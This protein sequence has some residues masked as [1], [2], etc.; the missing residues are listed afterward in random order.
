MLKEL[1]EKLDNL[2]E[3][4]AKDIDIVALKALCTVPET[5]EIVAHVKELV[6]KLEA[7]YVND[8]EIKNLIPKDEMTLEKLVGLLE[9]KYST[10][11]D[12]ITLKAMMNLE[13]SIEKERAV[14]TYLKKINTED[15]DIKK[16]FE[17]KRKANKNLDMVF[18]KGGEYRPSFINE[19]IEKRVFN[20]NVCRYLTTQD[21]YEKIM[22]KN[23]SNFKN[24]K[25]PVENVS[26]WDA[27][28]YCNRLSE[29]EYLEPVYNIDE[30]GDLKIN[31]LDGEVVYPDL[32]DFEKT[33]GYRLPTELEWE[34]FAR[35]GQKAIHDETFDKKYAGSN[36]IDDVAW[37]QGNSNNTT[38]IVGTKAPNSLNIFD[39]SGNIWEWCFDTGRQGGFT[40][41]AL[42]TFMSGGV[43]RNHYPQKKLDS[44]ENL[45][46]YEKDKNSRIVCGGS[47]T[48]KTF[49]NSDGYWNYCEVGYRGRE[50]VNAYKPDNYICGF[51]VVKTANPVI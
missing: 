21:S 51:R 34:W 28:E 6:E 24:T 10:N 45:Y 14:K 17:N 44:M 16:Y 3:N 47:Y 27:L 19:S 4:Y 50:T 49:D 31:Q 46:I 40:A 37:H 30:N 7:K 23:P 33:E 41:S 25:N 15:E 13:D 35:G 5:E 12:F 20:I 11:I 48:S 26:W 22:G 38:Q 42:A 36:N 29:K 39:C 2:P 1:K 8:D 9:G 43:G 18:V 32:A